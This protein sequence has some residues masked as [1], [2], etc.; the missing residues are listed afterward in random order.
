M[1]STRLAQAPYPLAPDSLAC[2]LPWLK[3]RVLARWVVAQ[4]ATL[5]LG[6]PYLLV[7]PPTGRRVRCHG[8]K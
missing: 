3:L 1:D 5:G 8:H 6:E 2:Y 7:Q 4:L